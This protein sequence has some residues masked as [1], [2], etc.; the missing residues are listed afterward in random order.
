MHEC[1]DAYGP[2]VVVNRVE[3]AVTLNEALSHL[4][5]YGLANIK[6]DAKKPGVIRDEGQFFFEL[7]EQRGRSAW[8][9]KGHGDVFNGGVE[10]F[11]CIV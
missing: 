5:A 11:V 8:G 1:D 4:F 2:F 7:V 9:T 3:N 6:V 10:F